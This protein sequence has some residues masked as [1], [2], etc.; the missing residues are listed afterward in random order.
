MNKN[1]RGCWAEKIAIA[2]LMNKGFDVFDS[3][4][5]NGPVDL[6]AFDRELQT[7]ALFEVKSENYRLTGPKKGTRIARARRDKTL[8]HVI[9]MLYVDKDGK[10][11]EG[12]V[13][14]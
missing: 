3:C 5:T 7:V 9:N 2:Y 8:R 10:I 14:E 11:R 13:R 4:Q 1:K 6:V 12:F